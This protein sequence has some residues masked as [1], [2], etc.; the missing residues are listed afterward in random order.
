MFGQTRGIIF[1]FVLWLCVSLLPC[2]FAYAQT[3][4]IS[5]LQV[6]SRQEDMLLFLN[7]EGAFDKK[8]DEAI[9]SGV[10]AVFSFSI[11]LSGDQGL[12][13]SRTILELSV[14]H[15]LKYNAMKNDYTVRRSWEDNRPLNTNTYEEA[16]KWMSEIENLRLLPLSHLQKGERYIIRSKVML[17]KATLPFLNY[18]FFFISLWDFESDWQYYRFIY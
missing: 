2:P 6:T 13:R 9:H 1:I 15:T 10:P 3:V 17:D 4:K 7:V 12:F 18:I 5:N 8:L 16:K 14:T 11:E